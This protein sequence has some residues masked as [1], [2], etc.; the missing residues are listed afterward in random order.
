MW[1]RDMMFPAASIVAK[2]LYSSPMNG[3]SS[4]VA[5]FL[6]RFVGSHKSSA[7]S[8]SRPLPGV[9]TGGR[10]WAISTYCPNLEQ[11]TAPHP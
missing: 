11:R 10:D 8:H 5:I 2:S 7:E 6:S 1:I 9:M 4:M 3:S